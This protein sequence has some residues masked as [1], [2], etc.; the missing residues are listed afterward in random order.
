MAIRKPLYWLIA[1]TFLVTTLS[2][3]QALAHARTESYPLNPPSASGTS[4]WIPREVIYEAVFFQ[5]TEG[6]IEKATTTVISF[7][8][9]DDATGVATDANLVI[10]FNENI[11]K[12][13]GNIIIYNS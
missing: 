7:D 13:T 12:G 1:L 10:A 2:I 4:K 6:S 8:P 11:V 3:G 5:E 9:A